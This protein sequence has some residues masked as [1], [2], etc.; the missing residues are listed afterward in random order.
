MTWLL[1][2][3]GME[4]CNRYHH[5]RF[6]LNYLC[7]VPSFHILYQICFFYIVY[8]YILYH[9]LWRRPRDR[10][11]R[12]NKN[13]WYYQE[14][15][16]GFSF[17]YLIV[18]MHLQQ[19]SSDARVPF[20]FFLYY[21]QVKWYDNK[22]QWKQCDLH[23]CRGTFQSTLCHSSQC[24]LN[25]ISINTCFLND[26]SRLSLNQYHFSISP[27]L[28]VLFA[29]GGNIIEAPL[30]LGTNLSKSTE[31]VSVCVWVRVHSCVSVQIHR[32]RNWKRTAEVN[33][34][35][36]RGGTKNTTL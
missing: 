14:Q 18:P 21:K 31:S 30:N 5:I 3:Q 19:D 9:K 29:R 4:P 10:H 32:E 20:R 22:L 2:W 28:I 7:N 15:C 16:A 23:C 27:T 13:K 25:S 26:C 1:L 11:V 35:S 8:F 36:L 17:F 12:F 24:N 6:F 34:I 33:K